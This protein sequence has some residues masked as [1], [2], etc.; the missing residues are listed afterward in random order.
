MSEKKGI[1]MIWNVLAELV[2]AAVN[3]YFKSL[4]GGCFITIFF[5]CYIQSVIYW[6]H[7]TFDGSCPIFHIANFLWKSK[8]WVNRIHFVLAIHSYIVITLSALLKLSIKFIHCWVCLAKF[9]ALVCSCL[10]S[11]SN[12]FWF[13][14][15]WATLQH[16]E[17]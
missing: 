3:T 9:V 5:V 16:I 17:R 14:Y 8:I 1:E 15:A 10:A 11:A 2:F 7:I 4:G 12:R 13:K 6:N